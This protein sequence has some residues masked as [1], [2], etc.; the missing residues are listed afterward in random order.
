MV[1]EPGKDLWLF[2]QCK[3]GLIKANA[4]WQRRGGMI[5][6]N[7]KAFKGTGLPNELI[8]IYTDKKKLQ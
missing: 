1:P 5:G 4:K 7:C 2:C 3:C 8:L 6:I